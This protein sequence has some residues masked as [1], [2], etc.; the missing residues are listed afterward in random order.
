MSNFGRESPR[1]IPAYFLIHLLVQAE[2]SFKGFFFIFL[3]LVAILFNGAELLN[4]FGRELPKVHSCE[5]IL[6]CVYWFSRRRCC[7]KL[8]I[9][10]SPGGHFVQRSGTV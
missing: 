9:I 7:L 3:A 5:I 4:N 1:N 8:F 2:K 6:K 10:Y